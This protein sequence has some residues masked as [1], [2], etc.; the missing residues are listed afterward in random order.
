MFSYVR[1]T[2]NTALG[3]FLAFSDGVTKGTTVVIFISAR[4]L[5]RTWPASGERLNNL[6]VLQRTPYVREVLVVLRQG[7]SRFWAECFVEAFEVP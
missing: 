7:R 5:P 4:H 2:I 1:G 3:I 6:L